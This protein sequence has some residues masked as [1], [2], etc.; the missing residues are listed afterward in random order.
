[1][2]HVASARESAI[3]EKK[4]Q[5]VSIGGDPVGFWQWGGGSKC[6]RSLNF[7]CHAAIHGL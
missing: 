3:R 2:D 7:Y 5:F 4:S 6:A 1:M